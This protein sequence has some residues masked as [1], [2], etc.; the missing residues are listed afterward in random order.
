MSF[1]QDLGSVVKQ[2]GDSALPVN[3]LH[4]GTAPAIESGLAVPADG[5]ATAI[6]PMVLGIVGGVLA[7]GL[8]A[9]G[10]VTHGFS[11]GNSNSPVVASGIEAVE[12]LPVTG[13]AEEALPE[14][15]AV[16]PVVVLDEAASVT[17][18]FP[19]PIAPFGV[20]QRYVAMDE[21]VG[22]V[23]MSNFRIVT[24]DDDHPA[25]E[26]WEWRIAD[27]K[28]EFSEDLDVEDMG[29]AWLVIYDIDDFS[30]D[31]GFGT[32]G[33]SVSWD[34]ADIEIEKAQ[35][36]FYYWGEYFE[37]QDINIPVPK[38]WGMPGWADGFGQIA[39]QVPVGYDRVIIGF[40]NC[41]RADATEE[42][43]VVL[44][45]DYIDDDTVWFRLK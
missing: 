22:T 26:G 41:D 32:G 1:H 16:D 10:I 5:G 17:N 33:A 7:A 8:I 34:G 30:L 2:P 35:I 31:G 15:A 12:E 45:R 23:T 42:L 3:D 9:G 38:L 44:V 21:A 6:K 36:D 27:I 20:P 43:D 40:T 13:L 25:R 29:V 18:V 14:I 4:I 37:D 28:T 39:V 19:F 24:S 11:F